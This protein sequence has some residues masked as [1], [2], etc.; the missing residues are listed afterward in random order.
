MPRI[1][2]VRKRRARNEPT[3]VRD[4]PH[5]HRIPSLA[6]VMLLVVTGAIPPAEGA[7]VHE[8]HHL[9]WH[10]ARDGRSHCAYLVEA[11][12]RDSRRFRHRTNAKTNLHLCRRSGG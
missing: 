10:W 12:A 11:I 2:N 9:E 6:G 3:A 1:F 4:E 5:A 7:L 8:R